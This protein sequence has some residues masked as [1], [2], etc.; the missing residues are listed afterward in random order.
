MD[1]GISAAVGV[2]LLVGVTVVLAAVIGAMVLGIGSPEPS[3]PVVLS[4]DATA[5]GR[6]MITHTSGPPINVTAVSMVIAIGGEP[7]DHQPPVPFF[8]ATG[9]AP[10]PTGAFN[11]AGDT[12]LEAGERATLEV[13]GTNDPALTEGATVRIRFVREE[14]QIAAVETTVSAA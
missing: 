2:P 11:E 3:E 4:A 14:T 10:G 7:L 6:I 13:A 1:R 5:D 9:F 12:V 8:S